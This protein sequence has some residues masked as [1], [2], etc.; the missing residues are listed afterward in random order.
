LQG[1]KKKN[2]N[3]NWSLSPTA[4]IALAKIMAPFSLQGLIFSSKG[5]NRKQIK[6]LSTKPKKDFHPLPVG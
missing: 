4:E 6:I 5:K 3:L 1:V 2:R